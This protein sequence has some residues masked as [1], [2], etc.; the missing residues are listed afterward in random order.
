MKPEMN[1]H[2]KEWGWIEFLD[3]VAQAPEFL[4][5]GSGLTGIECAKI[6][7]AYD[8]LYWAS[9]KRDYKIAFDNAYNLK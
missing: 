6:A 1:D 5:S 7:K 9:M 3:S 2:F 4:K 8:V